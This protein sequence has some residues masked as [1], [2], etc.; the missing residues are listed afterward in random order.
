MVCLLALFILPFF[1]KTKMFSI[2]GQQCSHH[3]HFPDRKLK[4]LEG[5]CT[6][7]P[8]SSTAEPH[9]ETK[10]CL[11]HLPTTKLRKHQGPLLGRVRPAREQKGCR[12]MLEWG[13]WCREQVGGSRLSKR[14]GPLQ[15]GRP[16]RVSGCGVRGQVCIL[17]DSLLL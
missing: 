9:S 2:Y 8:S 16:N 14:T 17:N 5:A 4:H 7:S 1:K 12:I 15:Q 6:R 13:L 3:P 10:I 11:L